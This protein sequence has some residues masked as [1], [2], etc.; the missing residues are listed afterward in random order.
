[1]QIV[2]GFNDVNY[3]DISDFFSKV[4]GREQGGYN[5]RNILHMDK[6]NLKQEEISIRNSMFFTA[7]IK[8]ELVG[9]VKCITDDAYIMY[10]LEVVVIPEQCNK[11]IDSHL[12]QDAISYAKDMRILKILLLSIPSKENFYIESGFKHILFQAMEKE[13]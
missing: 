2:Y 5:Y 3:K 9:Y 4:D 8:R 10:I 1:M 13:N 12:L 11:G 6:R 7:R